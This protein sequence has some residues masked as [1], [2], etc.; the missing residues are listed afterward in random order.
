MTPRRLAD[1][2]VHPIGLGAMPLSDP[3]ML[4]ERPRALA[5]VHAALDSGVTLVD[6]ADIYAPDGEHFGHNEVLVG[7]A[8][9]SWAGS[10]ADRARIVVA[11][12]G[13]ITRTPGPGGDV[14]GRAGTPQALG[15]AA[16][17]SARRLGVDEIDLYYLH[18]LDPAIPFDEQVGGL[19]AVRADGIARR[20]GLSNIT[21]AMLDR[22]LELV[23]GPEDGGIAAVQNEYSA[24]YRADA[25]VLARCMERGIAYLPWSP[26][27]GASQA[28]E[29]G[30][31]YAAFTEVAAARGISAQQV[32]LAWLLALGP[33]VIP[34]PGSTRPATARAS[35]A[36][37]GIEL[38]ADEVARLSATVP[39]DVSV[40]PDDT[41]APP[42]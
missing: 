39:E 10:E 13:G 11:T 33:Q 36:A 25:D 27:G 17:A 40:F 24:R 7:E 3:A 30:S 14:W 26:L 18:R 2:S 6:T 37:A 41:P 34:I 23:G 8:V 16:R 29:L 12:K 22:A 1:L 20:I 32:A 19:A 28:G 21:L 4:A 9:R 35:A 42:M 31:R 5:T 38:G 15:A